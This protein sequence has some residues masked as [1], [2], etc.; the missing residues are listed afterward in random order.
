MTE[1]KNPRTTANRA[2]TLV[3]SGGA[4]AWVLFVAARLTD[5][6]VDAGHTWDEFGEPVA[7]TAVRPSTYLI[8]AAIA[9]FTLCGLV[10]RRLVAQLHAADSVT[11]LPRAVL[12]FSNSV[13]IIGMV[14]AAFAAIF[15]FLSNFFEDS[16]DDAVFERV[17]NSYLPIVLY[18]ALV[19]TVILT[20]FVFTRPTTAWPAHAQ[21][22]PQA[23]PLPEP[24][25]EAT[26][27]TEAPGQRDVAVAYTLPI[28]AVAVALIFGLIVYDTTRT[29]LEAWV[30]VIVQTVIAAGITAGTI[31]AARATRRQLRSG[32][33]LKGVSVGA[34]NLNFILSI[35]FAVAVT[36][37]SLGYGTSAIDQLR[38]QPQLSVSVYSNSGLDTETAA[39]PETLMVNLYGS[40][41][42]RGTET[43]VTLE[44]GGQ[45]VTS[46]T[47][48]RYGSVWLEKEFPSGI[49]SGDYKLTAQAETIDGSAPK[50][51]LDITVTDDGLVEITGEPDA[52]TED[53]PSRMVTPT[54]GWVVGDLLAAAVL[55]ALVLGTLYVTINMRNTRRVRA[56]ARGRGRRDHL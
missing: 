28:V 14:L 45:A 51:S 30:W 3:L 31:F 9:V 15:V 16:G 50:V 55:L 25:P 17:L 46:E 10:G 53:E 56:D 21:V 41:L 43:T 6:I 1:P 36:G 22:A 48:D 27:I 7:T 12:R 40:D 34:K 35:I 5:I 38:V 19:I 49:E 33:P 26:E 11:T 52:Y 13:M 23:T 47:V 39:Q 24:E 44:P 4:L 2:L 20:G 32:A 8:F 42:A 37:M 18:T 29:Q 54:V